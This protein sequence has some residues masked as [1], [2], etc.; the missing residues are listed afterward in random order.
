MFRQF[1]HRGVH[2]GRRLV[3]SSRSGFLLTSATAALTTATLAAVTIKHLPQ[4]HAAPTTNTNKEKQ[5]NGDEEEDESAPSDYKVNIDL[6]KFLPDR[7]PNLTLR[8]VL[9]VT[10]HGSR[11]PISLLPG[12][13]REEFQ[14]VWENCPLGDHSTIPCGR[15]LLTHF[16]EFQLGSV[17]WHMRQRYVHSDKFFPAQFDDQFFALR[18]TDLPRTQLSLAR[19]VQGLYPG[20]KL[21]TLRPLIEIR[22]QENETMY[23]NHYFCPRL[24]ELYIEACHASRQTD[25][26]SYP[27]AGRYK[28]IAETSEAIELR[29]KFAKALKTPSDDLGTW[30]VIGDE[31]KCRQSVNIPHVDGVTQKMA[32]KANELAEKTFWHIMRAGEPADHCSM[33]PSCPN[34][35]ELLYKDKSPLEQ[36]VTR[37]GMGRMM[38]EMFPAM[39]NIKTE[40]EQESSKSS[41]APS[42]ST[43]GSILAPPH[44]TAVPKCLVYS[45]HDTTIAPLLASLHATHALMGPKSTEP[46][47]PTL[48]GNM[49][50][51]FLEATPDSKRGEDPKLTQAKRAAAHRSI[52]ESLAPLPPSATEDDRH[53]LPKEPTDSSSTSST[54]LVKP[55]FSPY[56]SSSGDMKSASKGRV[57]NR[58]PLVISPQSRWFIR[59]LVDHKEISIIP[60]EEYAHVR[61]QYTVQ[62]WIEECKQKSNDPLPPHQW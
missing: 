42:S 22:K 33:K 2:Y 3:S 62:N 34:S 9:F 6:H 24:K 31:L 60:F 12:Q 14:Q 61:Q 46:G 35:S 28:D 26:E 56:G 41:S 47:W 53:H 44:E 45:G 54:S 21:E 36:E 48:G 38:E 18:S 32:D 27:A 8:G 15:G 11:T 25:P 13:T 59:L 29:E 4:V 20:T 52:Q 43:N 17:G 49:I 1:I 16:G 10:R 7:P 5:S 58:A 23:P 39:E 40:R 37:L 55:E 57:N 50:L 19:M 30:V 51:E